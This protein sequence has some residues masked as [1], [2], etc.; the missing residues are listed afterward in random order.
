MRLVIQE[1]EISG[2]SSVARPGL[3]VCLLAC[4]AGQQ[5]RWGRGLLAVRAEFT[6]QVIVTLS[7]KR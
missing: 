6:V 3:F 1:K 4:F 5:L 2:S 7:C